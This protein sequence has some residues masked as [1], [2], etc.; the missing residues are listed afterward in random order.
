MENLQSLTRSDL[1]FF[2]NQNIQIDIIS[3]IISLG[4]AAILSF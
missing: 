2:V 1:S 3:F 4:C